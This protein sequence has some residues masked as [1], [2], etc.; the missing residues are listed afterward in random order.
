MLREALSRALGLLLLVGCERPAWEQES[1]APDPAMAPATPAPPG[2]LHPLGDLLPLAIHLDCSKLA[3][4]E[5][6][7]SVY[8]TIRASQ[9]RPEQSLIARVE[10][11]SL[12][13]T[14]DIVADAAAPALTIRCPP[15][16]IMEYDT[17]RFD[18]THHEIDITVCSPG[19]VSY[20]DYRT[21]FSS[22]GMPREQP[23]CA[24]LTAG[25]ATSYPYAPI[26]YQLQPKPDGT[27][28]SCGDAPSTL[29]NDDPTF[30]CPCFEE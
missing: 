3:D 19:F 6:P 12:C 7:A 16:Q 20:S 17:S 4:E 30:E 18:C 5:R 29:L 24:S 14:Y 21:D 11:D 23:S 22:C 28:A 9:V 26:V 2:P 27:G 8:V 1:P 25:D 10:G 13:E 15:R